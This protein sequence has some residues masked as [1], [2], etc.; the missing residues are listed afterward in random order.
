MIL[1]KPLEEV[2]M[3]GLS[4]YLML[5]QL[6]AQD[7]KQ[8]GVKKL[9]GKFCSGN[10]NHICIKTLQVSFDSIRPFYG[11]PTHLKIEIGFTGSLQ[12]LQICFI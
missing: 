1:S 11:Y 6:T 4:H 9:Y 2:V 12:T 10:I 3:I 5:G 7:L 8:L